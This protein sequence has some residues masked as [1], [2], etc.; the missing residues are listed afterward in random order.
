MPTKDGFAPGHPLPL[1]LSEHAEQPRQPGIGKARHRAVIP[2]RILKTGI[3][4][5]TAAAIDFAILSV[6]DPVALFASVTASLV[7][8]SA[9]QPATGQSTPA[10]QS[11]AG[12]EDLPL[13]ARQAPTR[14]EIAAALKTAHLSQT[15][16]GQPSA[17]AS[18]KEFQAWAVAEEAGDKIAAPADA[19]LK[20]F[21]AWA[22]EEE[23]RT[24]VE[25]VPPVEPVQDAP[26]QAVQNDRAQDQHMDQP[27]QKH[28][29]VRPA[30]AEI[31]PVHNPRA[32][33]RREQNA[34]VQVRPAQ[35]ARVQ[36]RPAQDARAQDGSGQNAQA[37][38]F[39]QSLGWRN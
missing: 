24:Q 27:L 11:T 7:D 22:A 36:V 5:V 1:F 37:P 31:R 4:V 35:D 2:S 23:A 39:L 16:T 15:E 20:Q 38:S 26:A 29:Q 6:G 17:E 28:R 21:Q 10:I 30:R 14:D 34:R 33:V 25:P 19:L 3:L 13:T 8:T 18:L 12:A 32:K 9:L